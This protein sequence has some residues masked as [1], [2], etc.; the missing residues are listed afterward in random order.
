MI[1]LRSWRSLLFVP[2]NDH[3]KIAGAAKTQADGIVLDLEDGVAEEQ[4]SAARAGLVWAAESLASGRA[5][6]LVRINTRWRDVA[7]DLDAT[8]RAEVA[9]IVIPKVECTGRVETILQMVRELEEDRGLPIGGIGLVPL[10]ETARGLSRVDEVSTS[11]GVIAVAFGPEDFAASVGREPSPELLSLP[12]KKIALS[13]AS[14]GVMAIGIPGSIADFRTLDGFQAAA[15]LGCRFGMTGS[16]CIHPAQV[17]V[18]NA[19]FGPSRDEFE[20]SLAIVQAFDD[21]GGAV[22]ALEGRM[23]DQ[24]VVDRAHRIIRDYQ[25]FAQGTEK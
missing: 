6:V 16:L 10:I 25:T 7:E 23:I 20:K 21:A 4:K 3:R 22:V 2:A 12:C 18:L 9:A 15:V 19:A 24:P 17:G 13:A 11:K 1:A 8:V 14:Q 5:D